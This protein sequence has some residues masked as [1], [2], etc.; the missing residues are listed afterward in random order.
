MFYGVENGADS[1]RIL[2]KKRAGFC[3][4]ALEAGTPLIPVYV[5]G[6]NTVYR[7]K[8]GPNS[9]AAKISSKLQVSLVYW[10]DRFGIPWGLVPCEERLV[11]LVGKPVWI[12]EM[13]YETIDSDDDKSFRLRPVDKIENPSQEQIQKLQEK[14]ITALKDL[15]ERNK[16]R[17]GADW[18]EKK[19]LL[20]D[21]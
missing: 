11:V 18:K 20:E 10:T 19:L 5:M 3:K 6:A 4:L 7:R 1:E 14:Y 16:W 2:L 8:F 13:K 21:E 15:F 9:W 12:E 17:K